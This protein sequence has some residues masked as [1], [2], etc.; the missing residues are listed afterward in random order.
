MF[1]FFAKLMSLFSCCVFYVVLWCCVIV[2]L[3]LLF[4]L[5]P[6]ALLRAHARAGGATIQGKLNTWPYKY[7]GLVVTFWLSRYIGCFTRDIHDF[8]VC[9]CSATIEETTITCCD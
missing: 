6:V 3:L 5:P 7:V 1:D 9:S 8:M 4:R 2:C